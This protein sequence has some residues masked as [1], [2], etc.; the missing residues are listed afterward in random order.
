MTPKSFQSIW[1]CAGLSAALFLGLLPFALAAFPPDQQNKNAE[2]LVTHEPIGQRGGR[3]V[4]A[5]RA[6]PKT[7]NPVIATDAPSRE[8]IGVNPADL[9]HI[10]RVSQLTESALAKSCKVFKDGLEYSVEL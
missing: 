5:L 7:L 10:N 6:E 8:V 9:S 3:L 4:L 1:R 2:F